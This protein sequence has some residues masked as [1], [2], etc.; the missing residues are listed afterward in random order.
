MFV[1]SE[2][3]SWYRIQEM[4]RFQSP[5]MYLVIA[6]ALVVAL[7]SLQLLR[8]LGLRTMAGEPIVIRPKR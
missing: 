8:W 5:H 4:F 7:L 6:S 1:K 2:V 3:L